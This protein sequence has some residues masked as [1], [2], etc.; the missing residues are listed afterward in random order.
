MEKLLDER[1]S[2]HS[3]GGGSLNNSFEQIEKL[4]MSASLSDQCVSDLFDDKKDKLSSC[5]GQEQLDLKLGGML[6]ETGDYQELE[7]FE[8]HAIDLKESD[9]S[10]VVK[11]LM[12][13]M[14][15]V[16]FCLISNMPG[17]DEQRLFEACQAFHKLPASV[18]RKLTVAHFG[19]G[20][21]NIY[22]GYFPFLDN[23]PSHKEFYDMGRP[24]AD[25][26]EWER[27]GC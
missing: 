17:H 8:L 10:L 3:N 5:S 24:Y 6:Q 12:Q 1:K 2:K 14:K 15:T 22:H 26:S 16:G 25:Y 9:T 4:N 20:N 18:K 19:P 21:S 23:D 27:E 11:Q 13:Q 7:D